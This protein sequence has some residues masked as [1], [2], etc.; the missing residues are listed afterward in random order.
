MSK[1]E[2]PI[3]DFPHDVVF[4]NYLSGFERD[5]PCEKCKKPVRHRIENIHVDNDLIS[6]YCDE[7]VKN[8]KLIHIENLL[9]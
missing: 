1:K 4:T 8:H 2:K 3:N 5:V 7:C 6:Y 9:K